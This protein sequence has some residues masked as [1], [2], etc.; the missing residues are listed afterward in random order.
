MVPSGGWAKLSVPLNLLSLCVEGIAGA[1]SLATAGF[2]SGCLA[3]VS[4]DY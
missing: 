4:V 1:G 2:A 3:S